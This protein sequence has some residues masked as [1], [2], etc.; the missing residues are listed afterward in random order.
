MHDSYFEEPMASALDEKRQKA[1]EKGKIPFDCYKAIFPAKGNRVRCRLNL[2]MSSGKDGGMELAS[3]M[4]GR[5]GSGC[6]GC[7]DYDGD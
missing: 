4:S 3:V 1:R 6:R 5:S 2:K 7:K